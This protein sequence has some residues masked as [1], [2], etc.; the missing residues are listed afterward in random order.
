MVCVLLTFGAVACTIVPNSSGNGSNT[1]GLDSMA[2]SPTSITIKK[3]ESISLVNQTTTVHIIA[4]GRWENNGNTEDPEIEKGA[5][6]LN[7]VTFSAY[8]QMQ[9]VGPFTTTGTFYFYCSIH[10]GMNLVVIVQ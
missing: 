6:V 2:F 8:N 1:V 7:S 5:P 4:N 10:P 3:G 9:N